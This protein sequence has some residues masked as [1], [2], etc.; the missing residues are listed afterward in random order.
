MKTT[1][2]LK[3]DKDIKEKASKLA[4]SLGL[5]LSTVI[6]HSLKKFIADKKITFE[7]HPPFNKKTEK[8]M[9]K[10]LDD[11]KKG[12][13]LEGPFHTIDELKEYLMK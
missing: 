12:K 6:N 8:L 9:L 5:N 4:S 10:A 3:I 7:E 2:S 1:T 13:N 11:I